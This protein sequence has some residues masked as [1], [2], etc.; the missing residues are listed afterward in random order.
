MDEG[1]TDT[2]IAAGEGAGNTFRVDDPTS[3]IDYLM[4][5]GPLA[6][7]ITESRPLFEGAFRVNPDDPGSFALSDHLPVMADLSWKMIP[8]RQKNRLDTFRKN[9]RSPKYSH[10]LQ[11]NITS[12]S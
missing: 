10:T 3:R 2:H 7:R 11:R 4:A 9:L 12:G 8:K 6:E 1:W 5:Y